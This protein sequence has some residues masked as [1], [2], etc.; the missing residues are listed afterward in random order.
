MVINYC[1]KRRKHILEMFDA[2]VNQMSMNHYPLIFKFS[3]LDSI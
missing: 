2:F 1:T 3:Y